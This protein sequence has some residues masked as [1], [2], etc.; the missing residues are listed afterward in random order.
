ME[1]HN[2]NNGVDER[3]LQ[4]HHDLMNPY[5]P[6]QQVLVFVGAMDYWPNCDAVIWFAH[7]V[8]AELYRRNNC[9]RFYIVGSNPTPAVMAL[10]SEAGIVVV[11]RVESVLPYVHYAQLVVAPLRVARGVQNKVLEAMAMKRPILATEQAL[12]GIDGVTLL[13]RFRSD[14]VAK[15]VAFA[16][17]VLDGSINA[18]EWIEQGSQAIERHYQWENNCNTLLQRLK[19]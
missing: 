3:F 6:E 10:D 12:E 16:I 1:R 13:P 9:Y 5:P 7:Q 15:M 14:D 11:G 8:F 17:A 2:I 19:G 18:I 4:P